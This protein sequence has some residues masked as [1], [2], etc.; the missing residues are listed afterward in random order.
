M[1]KAKVIQLAVAEI[2][3]VEGKSNLNKYARIAGH[4]NNQPWC[5]TFISAIFIEA[6]LKNAIPI[7]ASC[8]STLAWGFKNDRVIPTKK[9]KRGDLLIFDFTINH[10]WHHGAD[11]SWPLRSPAI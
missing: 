10:Y 9:A 8:A 6:G 5:N 7:T 11:H 3:Y 4:A 1:S 2:G